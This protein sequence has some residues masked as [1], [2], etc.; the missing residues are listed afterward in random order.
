LALAYLHP[1]RLKGAHWGARIGR[2]PVSRFFVC[3]GWDVNVCPRWTE[4]A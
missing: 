3:G 4:Q 2:F 1:N